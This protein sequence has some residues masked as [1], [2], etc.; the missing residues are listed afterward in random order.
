MNNPPKLIK[1]LKSKNW[2]N[3]LFET[4]EFDNGVKANFEVKKDAI[5]NCFE[6]KN[7]IEFGPIKTE[8]IR[9]YK[10]E[11]F[12][13]FS[14]EFGTTNTELFERE[15]EFCCNQ[16]HT[17][18]NSWLYSG[19][20][21]TNYI[22][23][24]EHRITSLLL[25]KISEE[26]LSVRIAHS[27]IEKEPLKNIEVKLNLKGKFILSPQKQKSIHTDYSR[28]SEEEKVELK[29]WKNIEHFKTVGLVKARMNSWIENLFKCEI[30]GSDKAIKSIYVSEEQRL[31]LEYRLKESQD[32]I[33]NLKGKFRMY[34]DFSAILKYI[35]KIE[36]N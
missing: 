2:V 23:L 13:F 15:N 33:L 1:S 35:E 26:Y 10:S 22:Y 14:I 24:E 6:C 32:S 9:V 3:S 27:T 18:T 12:K 19:S 34:D 29:K 21:M 25:S 28:Y 16:V 5:S 36:P 7:F 31:E 20:R 30:D 8:N 4:F 17:R 11:Y